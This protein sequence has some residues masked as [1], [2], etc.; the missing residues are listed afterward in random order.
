MKK[1]CLL[2]L[3]LA[4]GSAPA[5]TAAGYAAEL[6]KLAARYEQEIA[7]QGSAEIAAQQAAMQLYS[8]AQ[9]R[10]AL[11]L[12][13]ARRDTLAADWAVALEEGLLAPAEV[14][15]VKLAAYAREDFEA[16]RARYE[17]E[18]ASHKLHLESATA[19]QQDLAKVNA[20]RH[21]LEALATRTEPRRWIE[22]LRARAAEMDRFECVLD[23]GRMA[24][25]AAEAQRIRRQQGL[26]QSQTQIETM[27][28][29]APRCKA[30]E[31][32]RDGR[33]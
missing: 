20:L 30:A 3:F 2:F 25:F 16:L 12:L 6:A 26:Q 33:Q 14:L 32:A 7:E 31:E 13:E 15:G 28:D 23:A 8:T 29:R 24:F 5:Q 11:R 9:D 19:L 21:S 27:M 4:A 22:Q 10:T 17:E 18:A 1:Q